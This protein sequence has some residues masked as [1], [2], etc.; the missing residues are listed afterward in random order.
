MEKHL[1]LSRYK[2][3]LKLEESGK[4]EVFNENFLELLTYT[5]SVVEQIQ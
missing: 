5:A 2:E 1:N 4:M 3:L